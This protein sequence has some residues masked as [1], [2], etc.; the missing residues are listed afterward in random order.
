MSD[1]KERSREANN[2]QAQAATRRNSSIPTLK[3]D[4]LNNSH[5]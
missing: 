2:F 1:A 4:F 5:L 3:P